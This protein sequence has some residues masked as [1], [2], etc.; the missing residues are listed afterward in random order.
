MNWEETTQTAF[1]EFVH[2]TH[3]FTYRCPDGYTAIRLHDGTLATNC[4][5]SCHGWWIFKSCH[6]NCGGGVYSTFWC[7]AESSV[8]QESGRWA[9]QYRYIVWVGIFS[10]RKS[11]STLGDKRYF[12]SAVYASKSPFLS[13]IRIGLLKRSR[14]RISLLRF[15]RAIR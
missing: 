9:T 4:H 13:S 5:T 8:P 15:L 14:A 11:S 10:G 3:S 6:T 2:L 1:D 7:A 12:L